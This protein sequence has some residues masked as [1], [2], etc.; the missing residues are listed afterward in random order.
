MVRHR[1]SVVQQGELFRKQHQGGKW[2][3]DCEVPIK[4]ERLPRE[5]CGGETE[6][7]QEVRDENR[8]RR[9]G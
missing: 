3:K 9:L 5:D 4:V 8:C 2:G 1:S 7:R 6:I